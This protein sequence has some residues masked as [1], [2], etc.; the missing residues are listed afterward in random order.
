[1]IRKK[2]GIGAG[3]AIFLWIAGYGKGIATE[4]RKKKADAMPAFAALSGPADRAHRTRTGIMDSYAAT[5]SILRKVAYSTLKYSTIGVSRRNG[6][7]RSRIFGYSF[8]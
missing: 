5:V 1:M 7:T 3:Q 8:L 2:Q 4:K 6:R